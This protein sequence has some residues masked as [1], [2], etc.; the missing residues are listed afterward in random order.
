MT[1][2]GVLDTI[3]SNPE[4]TSVVLIGLALLGLVPALLTAAGATALVYLLLSV[5]FGPANVPEVSCRGAGKGGWQVK[6]LHAQ[7]QMCQ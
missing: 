1:V 7:P 3:N 5:A 4:A 6:S 2:Y